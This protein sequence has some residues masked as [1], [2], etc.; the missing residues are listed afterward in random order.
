[1][2][3][4]KWVCVL[5]LAGICS[6]FLVALW[7]RTPRLL[8]PPAAAGAVSRRTVREVLIP[9][10][11]IR[12]RQITR[13][14]PAASPD[15]IAASF[16]GSPKLGGLS[17]PMTFEPNVGQTG[18]SV[19][20]VGKGKGLNVFLTPDEIALQVA[21][22][23]A[24]G[25]SVTGPQAGFVRLRVAGS[26]HLDWHGAGEL[27]GRSNYFVGNNRD[28]WH[29][30]VPHFARAETA[31][32][33]PGV[34]MAVYGTDDG[35]EYDLQVAPGA[36]VSSLR[37]QL[38][39]AGRM[40]LD[41]KGDLLLNV[42]GNEV[43]M[44]KPRVYQAPRSGWH[45]SGTKRHGAVGARRADKYSPKHSTRPPD[46]RQRNEG[47]V[48]RH[49]SRRPANP[50]VHHSSGSAAANA[51]TPCAKVPA[52]GVR[53]SQP[54]AGIEIAANYVIEP[55]GTIGF[56]IGS[57][58]HDAP[59][60]IDPSLS[61]SYAT[62]LGGSGADSAKSIAVDSSGDIYIAGTTVSVSFPGVAIKRIGPADGSSNFFIAK[63][64]PALTGAASLVY[65]DFLGGG[66]AQ[67][68][69]VIA[70]DASGDVAL[71]GATTASDYPVTDTSTP[72]N[73]LSS[74][75]GN[76]LVVS[77]ISPAGNALIYSTLFGGSGIESQSG[78]GGIA[79]DS[80]G[81][82]YI[83]SDVHTSPI[84]SASADLPVTGSAYLP[85]WD[86]QSGD[87]FFAILTPPKAA[88]SPTV[89]KYCTYLGT[90]SIS[91]PGIAGVAIDVAGNA[92]IAGT[93]S[94]GTNPFPTIN[95]VQATYGGGASDG[96]LLKIA[97]AG[98]GAA[99]L[100]YSTLLGGSSADSV[101]AVA[102]DDSNPPNAYLAGS[103]QSTNFPTN[104]KT[105]A[106]QPAIHFGAT[107]N[108]FLAVVSQ[109]AI[110]G[111]STLAYS[112]YLGGSGPDTANALAVAAPNAVYIAG[113]TSSWDMP[114]NN[115]LQPF[116][117][118][119]DAFVA[120]FDTTVPAAP[121]LLY[122]TP[123]GGTSQPGAPAS[124]SATAL[125]ADGAGHVYVAGATIANN[126]PTALTTKSPNGLNGFQPACASCSLSPSATDAFAAEIVESAVPMPSVYFN[127]GRAIFSGVPLGTSAVPV[128][129]ALYNG[130][131]ANLAI[132]GISISGPNAS[133]FSLIGGGD[134][135]AQPILPGA[136][137]Q[138][139]FEVE[140]APTVSGA[141]NA[142]VLVSD[143]AP[144]SPQEL[145]LVANG[146]AA[147]I[148][149]SP[150]ALAFGNQ[151]QSTPSAP[152]SV[153]VANQG[154][155]SV[156]VT[157]I[158]IGGVD[159][160]AFSF[161][162]GGDLA[163]P[164]CQTNGTIGP[165]QSC[166]VS[167]AFQPNALRAFSAQ[168]QL[169]EI[170]APSMTVQQTVNLSGTGVPSAPVVVLSVSSV[171]FGSET[172][173]AASAPQ[174]VKVT[175]SGSATLSFT[176]VGL[177][178]ANVADFALVSSAPGTTCPLTGGSLAVSS[179]C[180]VAIKFTPQAP[181]SEAASVVF[182]D[183]AAPGSQ[184]V[185]L[186][187]TATAAA[188]LQASPSALTFAAQSEGASSAAQ[189][190][191][192][193]NSGTSPAQVGNINITGPNASDFTTSSS[194]TVPAGQ[195]CQLNI[196]F[197][198]TATTPGVRT[199]TLNLPTVTPSSLALTG[200]A[201]QAAIAVPTSM[202]FGTQLAGGAG[203]SPQ[204]L[205]VTNSSSGQYAGTL[206]ISSVTKTGSNAGDFAVASD[207]CTGASV[208]PAG[209]CSIQV[210]FKP[211]PSATCTATGSARSAVLT[212]TDNAPGSPHT[213]PLSGTAMSFCVTTS[214]TQAV[215]GPITA[216]GPATYSLEVSSF[217]GF[218]GSAA[219]SCSVQ[220]QAG[221]SEP[222][223]VTGCSFNL[224]PAT[225]Q[226]TPTSPGAFQ[227]IVNTSATPTTVS[228][229]PKPSVP[230]GRLPPAALAVMILAL[231]LGVLAASQIRLTARVRFVQVAGLVVICA[232]L[233]AACGGGG[234]AADPPPVQSGVFQYNVVV[235]ATFS[236]AGQPNVQ[237]QFT[238]PMVVDVN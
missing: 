53:S 211:L 234:G 47:Q 106:F 165:G 13:H 235:T 236:A 113:S 137:L 219:L 121:G 120:K 182:T 207:Q 226:V 23:S 147:L 3:K 50:C 127:I 63:I 118:A 78:P 11:E 114:W 116:N 75:L 110:S 233:M 171:S 46:V 139:S 45:S 35:V 168:L 155:Q 149:I 79:L 185:T 24:G 209:A 146:E 215:Q 119:S 190:I 32:S 145:E 177:S 2:S 153:T 38:S 232:A 189:A 34:G 126:F 125:A 200:T 103:T 65:L 112:T 213:V 80:S 199:A 122:A 105:G 222:D 124:A 206:A 60:V 230:P 130:G 109:N 160:S 40:R 70:V 179:S 151:P 22:S 19:S 76:D 54:E 208:A 202:N 192:I 216:G 31:T 20:F 117:G 95:A 68:G 15:A 7:H 220:P 5:A 191:T 14:L 1:M 12:S 55:D 144:G 132:S 87:A 88:G 184:Q 128:P 172:V 86:G 59:L 33:V 193:A 176:S 134:C 123:L 16:A 52:S 162:A 228:G 26:S 43:R 94:I 41:A 51:A 115:N 90:N 131:S 133:D 39:G 214:P 229:A 183:N 157:N 18:A 56:Q 73:G 129:V 77:E 104:G 203:S 198:P 107:S 69:G 140:F 142:V 111:Q 61:V 217:G 210:S 64:N 174:S 72:T 57:Y 150:P 102:L 84:D 49:R 204:P 225:V 223:Y 92:Y 27:P 188:S 196:T 195:S 29:T 58:D 89:V 62:F 74:G 227:L 9:N 158:S 108:A 67:S 180:S 194:C 141:E 8:K 71:S 48:P 148:S 159:S 17:I 81:D 237:S 98:S 10:P 218:S 156:T 28:R 221:A 167:V 135:T 82:I 170:A 197:T 99:D 101:L 85:T 163:G 66:G 97:P 205:V 152:T 136:A 181:G 238:I 83:A 44:K 30:N 166:A 138:C 175:N 6:C 25:A 42:S 169:T 164:L 143:N 224:N 173:G 37:L 178:G 231:L 187:G 186:S 100:V 4:S 161:Q 93:V 96:F 21:N 212:L 154:T 91:E 36:N 201:T